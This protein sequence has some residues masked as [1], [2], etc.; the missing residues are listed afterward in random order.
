MRAWRNK[1]VSSILN[2]K[3]CKWQ[4]PANV[5]AQILLIYITGSVTTSGAVTWSDCNSFPRRYFNCIVIFGKHVLFL[6]LKLKWSQWSIAGDNML[7]ERA[8][9]SDN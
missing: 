1:K 3:Q 6:S 2:F 9:N 8:V 7:Y 4:F 5:R